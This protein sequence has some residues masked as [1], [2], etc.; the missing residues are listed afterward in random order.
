MTI[1]ERLKEAMRTA[2]V[3]PR[4][5]GG[6]TKIHFVTLYRIIGDDSIV[7]NPLTEEAL[8]KAITKLNELVATGKLPL[9]GQMSRKEKTDTLARLLKDE[10]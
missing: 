8:D 6:A 4:Q 10:H 3:N 1:G 7:P 9:Q 5:L 2:G